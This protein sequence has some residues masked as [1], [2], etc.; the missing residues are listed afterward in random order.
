MFLSRRLSLMSRYNTSTVLSSLPEVRTNF[1]RSTQLYDGTPPDFSFQFTF[2]FILWMFFLELDLKL[3]NGP[4]F[5]KI[6]MYVLIGMAYYCFWLFTFNAF[7]DSCM[8][9]WVGHTPFIQS[10]PGV[11]AI[12]ASLNHTTACSSVQM[13]NPTSRA[14][15]SC[16]CDDV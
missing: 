9:S 3:S 16:Q 1:Q 8:S 15:W 13:Y 7:Q 6:S 14:S 2:T 12:I 11:H 4:T 10:T 5:Y